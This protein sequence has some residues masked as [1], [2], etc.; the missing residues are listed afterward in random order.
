MP[1]FSCS[2]TTTIQ[3]RKEAFVTTQ[4]LPYLTLPIIYDLM[5]R[6]SL[7]HEPIT[8]YP[9]QE[10]VGFTTTIFLRW[11]CVKAAVL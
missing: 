6:A 2:F 9:A 4:I 7:L 3:A 1:V 8:R 10:R 5:T 11:I